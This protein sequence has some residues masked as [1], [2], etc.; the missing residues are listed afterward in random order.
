MLV[1]HG[2]SLESDGANQVC[3]LEPCFFAKK[4]L[5]YSTAVKRTQHTLGAQEAFRK[6]L[7]RSSL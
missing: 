2:L 6:H 7:S 1:L 5:A 4:E 3:V